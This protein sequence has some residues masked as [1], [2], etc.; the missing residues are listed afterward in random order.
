MTRLALTLALLSTPALADLRPEDSL[1]GTPVVPEAMTPGETDALR[2]AVAACWQG[3]SALVPVTVGFDLDR[4]G[5]VVGDP[6]M[7][8]P[9][10]IDP[11][12]ADAAFTA[13]ARAI[14][15]CQGAGYDLPARKYALWQSVEIVFDPA[16]G[17]M[18]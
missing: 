16:E 11:E 6:R 3:D 17:P 15:R 10:G 18:R 12:L 2:L 5:R 7:V 13:A 8:S 9:P 4:Q 1:A 14:L